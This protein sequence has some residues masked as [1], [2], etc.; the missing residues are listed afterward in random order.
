MDMRRWIYLDQ[1]LNLIEMTHEFVDV[2]WVGKL[3]RKPEATWTSGTR[4]AYRGLAEVPRR[5]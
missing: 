1:T 3:N 2:F 5:G 4:M